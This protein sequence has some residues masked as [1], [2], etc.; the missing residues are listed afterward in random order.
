VIENPYRKG[1][2]ID[3]TYE[4]LIWFLGVWGC[5]SSEPVY[6][7]EKYLETSTNWCR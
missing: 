5:Y 3:S 7:I 4:A 2:Y 6:Y 1:E